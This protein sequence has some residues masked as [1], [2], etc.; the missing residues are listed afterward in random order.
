MILFRFSRGEENQDLEVLRDIEEAM[1]GV[2]FDEN[3]GT[4]LNGLFLR[5]DAHSSASAD[6]VV[7]FVLLVWLLRVRGAFG[8]SVETSAHGWNAQKFKISFTGSGAGLVDVG[9]LEEVWSRHMALVLGIARKS[10][11]RRQHF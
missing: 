7:K 11:R 5:V 9:D 2:G 8:E 3:H 6:D 10:S 4:C 1:I